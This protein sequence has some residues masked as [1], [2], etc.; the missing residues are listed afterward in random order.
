[1]ETCGLSF[2]VTFLSGFLL[3]T[4]G[5][6]RTHHSC[7]QVRRFLNLSL[8]VAIPEALAI[9]GWEFLQLL[10]LGDR[11]AFT[12]ERQKALAAI[13][14]WTLPVVSGLIL[15]CTDIQCHIICLTGNARASDAVPQPPP[16]GKHR[17][18]QHDQL[19]NSPSTFQTPSACL[20]NLLFC[21]PA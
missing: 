12:H 19:K 3:G 11:R 1:M 10:C 2:G 16:P 14:S 8:F 13:H 7:K 15:D 5:H 17:Q 4:Y 9:E 18:L 20:L 21:H 6:T